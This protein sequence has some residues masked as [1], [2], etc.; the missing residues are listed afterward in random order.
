MNILGKYKKNFE[1]KNNS[2]LIESINQSKYV[3]MLHS[4]GLLP[5]ITNLSTVVIHFISTD[6]TVNFSWVCKTNDIFSY[7][8]E[9]LYLE[10]PE[11]KYKKLFFLSNGT[12]VNRA[13]SLEENKIKDDNVIVLNECLI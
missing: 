9:K 13:L 1:S 11:L 3:K 12:L 5:I 8:E 2:D 10:Y 4:N 7:I 6:S